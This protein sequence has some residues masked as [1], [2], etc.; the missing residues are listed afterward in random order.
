MSTS[1]LRAAEPGDVPAMVELKEILRLTPGARRG[2]FLLGCSPERYL[3][4]VRH[5]STILLEVDGRLAGFA[6]ALPDAVLRSSELWSRRSAIAWRPDA[7]EPPESEGI[8]YF[9][10]L[11]LTPW[12]SRLHAAP[13]ALAAVRSLAEGHR[14]LYATTLAEPVCNHAAVPLLRAFGARIVGSLREDYP[15]V[16]PVLSWLHHAPME[17]GLEAVAERRDGARAFATAER[18]AA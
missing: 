14:H 6:I 15:E 8:A 16:G 2:G 17:A 5:A 7:G 4:L 11:A 13:L 9:D 3:Q 12:A 18:L 1:K 10:Q